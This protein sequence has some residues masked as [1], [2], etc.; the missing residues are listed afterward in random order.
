MRKTVFSMFL[1][2]LAV[3][4]ASDVSAAG[5]TISELAAEYN[6]TDDPDEKLALLRAAAAAN[7]EEHQEKLWDFDDFWL[8]DELNLNTLLA[9][10]DTSYLQETDGFPEEAK[11][12]PCIILMDLQQD[13]V[14]VSADMM[15]LLP[16]N[17]IASSVGEAEYAIVFHDEMVKSDY[18]YSPP[19]T[20]YHRDYYADLVNL[21]SGEGVRFWYHRQYAKMYGYSDALNADPMMLEDIWKEIRPGIV[22]AMASYQADGSVLRF[23]ISGGI[24]YLQDYEGNPVHIV[25]PEEMDGYPVREV[26]AGCFKDCVTLESVEI[27]GSVSVIREDAFRECINL[28]SAYFAEGLEIIEDNAFEYT[29]LTELRLPEGLLRIGE[30]TFNR[31]DQMAAAFIPGTVESIGSFAFYYCNKLTT[32]VFGEGMRCFP[33]G[34]FLDR[35]GNVMYVY[36]PESLVEGPYIDDMD[37]DV[38]IYAPEGSH[39]LNWAEDTGYKTVA[40]RNPAEIPEVRYV[41]EGNMDFRIINN[42]AEL[43]YYNTPE[44]FDEDEDADDE[45]DGYYDWDQYERGIRVIIPGEVS[46][47]PVTGI[48]SNAFD[49]TASDVRSIMLPASV[50]RLKHNA[51]EFSGWFN[52]DMKAELYIPNPETVLDSYSV[53]IMS[54]DWNSMTIFAPAGSLAEAYVQEMAEKTENTYYFEEWTE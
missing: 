51:I 38:V 6:N 49:H 28:S 3:I 10:R 18:I 30:N 53:R 20:S 45:D 44:E 23:G 43:E 11:G 5:R 42:E 16:L 54:E 35:Q 47:Y 13:R 31:N 46:G 29:A 12:R 9:V 4:F 14:R 27:P 37:K 33:E 36:L 52:D 40:C 25:I 48:L 21:Q 7:Q 34:Y 15:L 1:I 17:M 8:Q 19:A 22:D 50:R 32:V 26:G 41:Q 24:C 2:L 39:A